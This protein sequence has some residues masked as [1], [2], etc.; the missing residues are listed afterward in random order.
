MVSGANVKYTFHFVHIS[1]S[2]KYDHM[3]SFQG[4]ISSGEASKGVRYMCVICCIT[5]CLYKRSMSIIEKLHIYEEGIGAQ[6]LHP[7]FVENV[8]KR[9]R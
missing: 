6:I 4:D 5:L 2:M 1:Y 8:L 7:D 3:S 9:G